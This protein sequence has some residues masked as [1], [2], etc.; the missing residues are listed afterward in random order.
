MK[1]CSILLFLCICGLNHLTAQNSFKSAGVDDALQANQQLPQLITNNNMFVVV[2][3][4]SSSCYLGQP[5]LVTYKFYT[6]LQGQSKVIKMPSFSGCSVQEMTTTDI[7]ADIETLNGR[8]FKAY[9]IRKV[10]LTPLQVGAI[11]LDTASVENTFMVYDRGTTQADIAKGSGKSHDEIVV[12]HSKKT[13]IQVKELPADNKPTAFTGAIGNFSIG[14]TLT[15]NSDTANENNSI[16]IT[17]TGSG[18]FANITCPT[19]QWPKNIEH[20]EPEIFEDYNK[21]IFPNTGIISFKIPFVVKE[22]GTYSIPAIQ[23]HYFDLYTNTYKVAYTDTLSLTVKPA[24]EQWVDET[25]VS[26]DITNKKYI[27]IVPAIAVLVG[28]GWFIKYGRKPKELTL[29]EKA[30]LRI[31]EDEPIILKSKTVVKSN[32]Q[33]VKELLYFEHDNH[34]FFTHAKKLIE[35]CLATSAENNEQ[36][37]ALKNKLQTCNAALYGGNYQVNKQE[38]IAELHH[39]V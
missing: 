10:Q 22:K 17:I 16:K 9:T 25:K 21:L 31:E 19:I 26:A 4:S 15:K 30:N 29:I 11:V 7:T 38:F 39:I 35:Q 18:N 20:F 24:I 32:Q 14:A 5:I 2:Q 1:Y 3:T 37:E 23:L 13:T 8:T 6:R 34:L 36:H 33:L 12:V 27:W 28:I